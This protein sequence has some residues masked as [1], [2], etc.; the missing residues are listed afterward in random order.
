MVLVSNGR[1]EQRENTVAG[2][3]R[4]VAT[5]AMHRLDHQAQHRVDQCARLLGIEIAHQL[6]RAL[7]VAEQSGD[8]FALAVK[9]F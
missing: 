2:R 8:R 3:L 9:H 1:A 4:Y 6:G 5:V 7:D